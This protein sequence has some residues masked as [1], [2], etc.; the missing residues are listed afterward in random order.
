MNKEARMS[1]R[2][3]ALLSTLMLL[4]FYNING[5]VSA[6]YVATKAT[7]TPTPTR[8]LT[9][10]RTPTYTPSPTLTSTLTNSPTLTPTQSGAYI[11]FVTG[12]GVTTSGGVSRTMTSNLIPSMNN[13]AK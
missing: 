5:I 10:S 7:N 12:T 9:P 4:F 13:S 1:L 8:T 11:Q 6:N 3:I 2:T